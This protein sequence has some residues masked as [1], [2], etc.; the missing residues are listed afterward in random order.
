MWVKNHLYWLLACHLFKGEIL[1][2]YSFL[3]INFVKFSNFSQQ[4]FFH[5]YFSLI[6]ILL[7]FF[8]LMSI[9]LN[10]MCLG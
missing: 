5:D 7:M 6:K 3:M 8:F 1:N 10:N 9:Q 4:F 2:L